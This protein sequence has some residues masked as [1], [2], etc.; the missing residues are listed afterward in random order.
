MRK[1]THHFLGPFKILKKV[2]PV[3][4]ELKIPK[5]MRIHDVFRVSPLRPYE[6]RANQGVGGLP[7]LLPMGVI[8]H[9]VQEVVGHHIDADI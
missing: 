8:E 4:Y 7:A 9:V 1:L 5:E 3:A 6:A 2:T